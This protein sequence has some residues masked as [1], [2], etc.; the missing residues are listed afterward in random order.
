MRA[1]CLALLLGALVFVTQLEEARCG[2]SAMREIKAIQDS[3]V[4]IADAPTPQQLADDLASIASTEV[5]A[6]SA[7]EI[8]SSSYCD[9]SES[10][11]V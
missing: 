5:D 8:S 6:R 9:G 11:G 2:A 7:P 1:L 10:M 3:V 4:V